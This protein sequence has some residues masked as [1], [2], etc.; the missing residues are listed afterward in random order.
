MFI[1]TIPNQR[2]KP[3]ILLREGYR[4]GGKVKTR[5]LANLSGL[6]PEKIEALRAALRGETLGG[7]PVVESTLPHGHVLAV[8]GMIRKLGLDKFLH[9]KRHHLREL[10]LALV[11]GR[12]LEP[13]SKLSLAQ[14]LA[15]GVEH[16]SLG[17]VLG[18][19]ELG[20][21]IDPSNPESS[22]EKRA[23]GEFYAAMDWLLERQEKVEDALAKLH[24]SSGC[25]VLYDLS[26]SYF[27]GHCCPL[28]MH[29]HTRDHRSDRPQVQ[30]GLLCSEEG[31]PIAIEVVEGNTGDPKTIPAQVA[32]L[33]DRFGLKSVVVV[34]DRGMITE[35]RIRED[36]SVVGYDW[37]SA[38]IHKSILPLVEAKV[39]T[40]SLF[41]ERGLAEIEHPDYHNERLIAC[42]NP[43]M[44]EECARKREELM[45]LTEKLLQK[46]ADACTRKRKPLEGA[47]AIGMKVGA[48]LGR[49]KMGKFYQVKIEEH[50]ASW[51][52]KPAALAREASMDGIYVIRTSVKKEAMDAEQA[53]LTYKGLAKVERA[54]RTLKSVD[55]QV[56]PI[57]HRL[58]DRVR[59]HLF[60]CMLAYYVEWHLRK[61]WAELLYTDEEGSKRETPVAPVQPSPS[62]K[63]KKAR[64]HSTS[65]FPLQSFAGLLKSLA[66]LGLNR[67]RV[68]E[69]GPLCT[70]PTRPTPFQARA[71]ELIGVPVA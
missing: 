16:H 71:F 14:S 5:T 20:K 64:A 42:F 11:A 19:G 58:E 52:R 54:F 7:D 39:I 68:G 66:S 41:D 48:V 37:I 49:F 44:A 67:V 6:P 26:S 18:L 23:A 15:K 38:L 25:T 50:S 61:G 47:A 60:I 29:G 12:V 24:L 8:T 4:E 53:V 43:I 40:P 63:L 10:S 70:R 65:G 69:N 32:K 21:A 28:A 31:I 34:G 27:E 1:A 3:A 51:T 17:E 57:Y 59:A 22:Q 33:K 45:G 9:G 55:L 46:V 36:L 56:R 35:A 30:Y 13:G 2:S 62:G